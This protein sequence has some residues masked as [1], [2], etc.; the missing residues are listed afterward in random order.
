VSPYLVA[1]DFR[2]PQPWTLGLL[3]DDA[4]ASDAALTDIIK[5]ASLGVDQ[6]T[7][8]HFEPQAAVTLDFYTYWYDRLFLPRIRAITS[9]AWR[10]TDDSFLTLDADTYQIV[11]SAF[12]ATTADQVVIRGRDY[13][14]LRT[15]PAWSAWPQMVRVIGNFAWPETPVDIKRA[16][17]LMVWDWVKPLGDPLMRSD[18]WQTADTLVDLSSPNPTRIPA[19]NDILNRYRRSWALVG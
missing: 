16:T 12:G 6:Y 11:A 3:L 1:N 4:E 5:E 14:E 17:A 8:D 19:A 13:L 7:D 18:R 15:W 10:Q 9:V 2:V